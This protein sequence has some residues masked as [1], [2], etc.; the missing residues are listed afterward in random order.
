MRQIELELTEQSLSSELLILFAMFESSCLCGMNR[1]SFEG[2]I[3]VRVL[4]RLLTPGTYIM[5][6]QLS[7]AMPLY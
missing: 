1:L 6:S 3:I 7:D 5:L 2:D 4:Y